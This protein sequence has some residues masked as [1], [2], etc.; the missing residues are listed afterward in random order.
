M[1]DIS[2]R[3]LNDE[4][5]DLLRVRAAEHGHSM[6]AEVRTILTDAVIPHDRSKNLLTALYESFAALG[7]V[8]LV[9]PPRLEMTRVPDLPE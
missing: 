5:R 7:G 6:E 9:I 2:I 8:E 1:A 3:G 4:V